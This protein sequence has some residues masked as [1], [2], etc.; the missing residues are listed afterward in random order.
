MLDNPP[1]TPWVLVDPV[2]VFDFPYHSFSVAYQEGNT[3]GATGLS[4]EYA[5]QQAASNPEVNR[6]G[7]VL[8]PPLRVFTLNFP[9]LKYYPKVSGGVDLHAD[10]QLNLARLDRFYQ[11]HTLADQFLYPSAYYGELLVRFM[12]PVE[13]P[14][15][16]AGG[17][18]FSEAITVKLIEVPTSLFNKGVSFAPGKPAVVK[19]GTLWTF[20]FPFHRVSTQY[21]P[22]SSGLLFGGN[23]TFRAGRS[24]PEQRTFKL[25]FESM[26]RR[27]T[28]L[29]KVDLASDP[30]HNMG[31]LEYFYLQHRNT[32]P[33]YY[34]HPVYGNIKVRFKTPP[35]FP[36]PLV[37]GGGW[38][39]P[40]EVE[41]IEVM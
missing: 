26:R 25:Q 19:I 34:P 15:G 33:F 7:L 10:P 17:L 1:L 22:E 20:D 30:Q 4:Y 11:T 5:A 21:R 14:F 27:L 16:V 2:P 18:G 29:G 3:V 12:E 9:G 23:Y 38:T 31:W 37:R 24:K 8:A 13:I 39:Q 41:L 28:P 36:E 40:V 6:R 32:E 35:T